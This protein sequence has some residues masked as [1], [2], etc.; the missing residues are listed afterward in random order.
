MDRATVSLTHKEYMKMDIYSENKE[1][2]VFKIY[3]VVVNFSDLEEHWRAA[4]PSRALTVL[5]ENPGSL[6]STTVTQNCL[7]PFLRTLC[8]ASSGTAHGGT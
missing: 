1:S 4:Q 2:V 3:L 5:P 6:S 7:Q 8:P